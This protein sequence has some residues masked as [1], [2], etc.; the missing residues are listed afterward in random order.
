MTHLLHIWG[1]LLFLPC[2][3]IGADAFS[4]TVTNTKAAN[5]R[6]YVTMDIR[7]G[8][9]ISVTKETILLVVVGRAKAGGPADEFGPP[10]NFALKGTSHEIEPRFFRV[11]VAL[12]LEKVNVKFMLADGK[13]VLHEQTREL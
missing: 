4:L 11:E 5:Q 6:R 3:V 1:L 9:K 2:T 10:Q 12:P 8:E 7:L 13:K